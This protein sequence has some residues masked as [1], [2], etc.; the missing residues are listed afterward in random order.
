MS[1][2]SMSKQ[3]FNRLGV[4]QRVQ[5][6]R[7]R[8]EDAAASLGLRRSQVFRFPRGLKHDGTPSLLFKRAH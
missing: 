1:V 6:G 5:S 3:E 8:V 7:L 2:L 4:L